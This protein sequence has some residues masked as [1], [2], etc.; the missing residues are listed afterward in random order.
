[1]HCEAV[2]VV[3]FRAGFHSSGSASTPP[4]ILFDLGEQLLYGSDSVV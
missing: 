4:E 2:C 1:M 3:A